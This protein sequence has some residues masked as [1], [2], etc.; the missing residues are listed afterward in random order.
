MVHPVKVQLSELCNCRSM[1][2]SDNPKG[3]TAY[4]YPCRSP[5]AFK[6][7]LP[8]ENPPASHAGCFQAAARI[9]LK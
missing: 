1:C 7:Q 8:E 2:D 3:I 4:I 5:G 9:H 6:L